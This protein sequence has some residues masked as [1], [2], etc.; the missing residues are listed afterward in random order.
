MGPAAWR[1][2]AEL[3]VTPLGILAPPQSPDMTRMALFRTSR[4]SGRRLWYSGCCGMCMMTHILFAFGL[5]PDDADPQPP[6]THHEPPHLCCRDSKL[7]ILAFLKQ[8]H[9]TANSQGLPRRQ[10]HHQQ[11][12]RVLGGVHRD[13]RVAG[14]VAPRRRVHLLPVHRLHAAGSGMRARHPGIRRA[15]P[16]NG[17]FS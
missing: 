8:P 12:A 14:D 3:V 10:H 13:T 9:N 4:N 16:H 1:A 11:G 6:N 17:R 7:M 2:K 15:S 5:S